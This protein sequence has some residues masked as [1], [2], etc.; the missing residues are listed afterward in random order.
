MI[1]TNRSMVIWTG[2]LEPNGIITGYIV[3][4]FNYQEDEIEFGNSDVLS[5][6]TTEYI[7]PNLS[8]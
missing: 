2:P 1:G 6:T 7:I 8:T 4:Y 3:I 5:N